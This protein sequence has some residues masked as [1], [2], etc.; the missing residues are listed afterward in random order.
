MSR[1]DGP[2][3]KKNNTKDNKME[4]KY[5]GPRNSTDTFFWVVRKM[6]RHIIV[7]LAV[8]TL[9]CAIGAAFFF[10]LHDAGMGFAGFVVLIVCLIIGFKLTPPSNIGD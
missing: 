5:Y 10:L 7:P 1:I 2:F 3:N 6:A 9:S 8:L 4:T